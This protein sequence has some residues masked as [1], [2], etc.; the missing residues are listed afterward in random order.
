MINIT[1]V[2]KKEQCVGWSACKHELTTPTYTS[3]RFSGAVRRL[4]LVVQLLVCITIIFTIILPKM[5][6]FLSYHYTYLRIVAQANQ[7]I[8]ILLLH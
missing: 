3:A 7:Q 8:I 1:T 5:I 4:D 6:V 2:K